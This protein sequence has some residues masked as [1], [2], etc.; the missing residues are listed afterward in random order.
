[1]LLGDTLLF[2]AQAPVLKG[3]QTRET[4]AG[5]FNRSFMCHVPLDL[6]EETKSKEMVFFF[7][8]F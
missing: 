3:R 7:F 6:S 1:M 5:V 8:F 2:M 4:H